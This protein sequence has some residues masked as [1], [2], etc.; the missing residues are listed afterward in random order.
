[1]ANYWQ[2]TSYGYAP[3][4][5]IT[6]SG[7]PVIFSEADLGAVTLPTDWT[8]SDP[9]LV[10]D[11][12]AEVGTSAIN[13][14][15]GI[16]LGLSFS[17]KL[18]DTD[19]VRDWMRRGGNQATLT[20]D[21]GHSDTTATVASTTG[22]PSS[23]AFY[24]GLERITYSGTTGTTFT[25]LT[26][27]VCGS[28]PQTHRVGTTG[29][30]ITDRPR[31]W[32]GRRLTLWCSLADPSGHV[33]GDALVSPE[34]VQVWCG[35]IDAGPDR[36]TDGF[37]FEAKSLERILED[38]LGGKLTG[39][40][41]S[42]AQVYPVDPGWTVGA[43][44]QGQNAAGANLW[45]VTGI[46]LSPFSALASGQL[47]HADAIR[48][49]ISSAWTQAVSDAGGSAHI[50]DL[51]FAKKS[52]GHHALVRIIQDATVHFVS[53]WL[54]VDG[55][56]TSAI[57]TLQFGTAGMTKDEQMDLNQYGVKD[58]GPGLFAPTDQT[59][60]SPTGLTV[61]LSEGTPADAPD[62]GMIRV[63]VGD[64][65]CT[66]TY[67]TKGAVGNSLYLGG[68][69]PTKNQKP[70]TFSDLS[71]DQ[72]GKSQATCEVLADD[73]GNYGQ[74]ILRCLETSGTGLRGAY[75][76]L[77]RGQG[78]ALPSTL[79]DSDSIVNSLNPLATLEA[80][81]ACAGQTWVDLFGGVLGLFRLALV[82]RPVTDETNTPIRLVM[83]E[84]AA[85]ANYTTTITDADLLSLEG[86]PIV[87]VKRADS[88]NV[89]KVVIQPS[90]QEDPD[91][92]IIN[93]APSIEA[94]GR[95]ET[96]YK[97]DALQRDS[98]QV[99]ATAATAGHF[100]YDQTVQAIEIRVHPSVACEVGDCV[101]LI[102][103]HPAVWTWATDPGQAGYS[104]VARCVG[105]RVN[106]KASGAVTLTL[107]IDGSLNL[108]TLAPSTE[109]LGYSATTFPTWIDISLAYLP[110]YSQAVSEAT[111]AGQT[112]QV[113][114]Y[115]PGRAEG[116][117]QRYAV[118]GATA[119]G[120]KCRLTLLTANQTGTPTIDT[121]KRSSVTLPHTAQATT[122]QQSGFTHTGDGSQ[123]G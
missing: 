94:Q 114:H 52:N 40:V 64:L 18:L 69:K 73:Q 10:I 39:D 1:M 15:Q 90:G 28:D 23:G 9:S 54:W 88:P 70:F 77:Q 105:R 96:T 92:L 4:W 68:L 24:A 113:S 35:R 48:T 19:T 119:V 93:D 80:R 87:S 83:V 122:Y 46:T 26:R 62:T 86:D 61:R 55:K 32:R 58:L 103:T 59:I 50:G 8:G 91:N 31:Y 21:L 29:Q 106:L 60:P 25:G 53:G 17:A 56:E 42:T 51:T 111:A 100:A 3:I 104:G 116:S 22:W 49:L 89:V 110:H 13:R 121:A 81:I 117:G 102:T 38:G 109:I 16:G 2:A 63:Q 14:E 57:P 72:D 71:L 74:M 112:V 6:V 37:T 20:V 44:F 45:T 7:I 108:R 5:W 120:G 101:K 33:C 123:W 118:S 34:A 78:Y 107:L 99:I 12:S 97:V 84:T 41:E 98:L 82:S 79:I 30:I 36:E 66:Y 75:D 11:D 65:H 67:A 27:G 43:V 47:L 76:T 85:G 95:R 115:Q